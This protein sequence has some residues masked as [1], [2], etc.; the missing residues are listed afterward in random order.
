MPR[1][2]PGRKTVGFGGL[3]ESSRAIKSPI[4]APAFAPTFLGPAPENEAPE[5]GYDFGAA[6]A[7]VGA[8]EPPP[9]RARAQCLGEAQAGK[10][11]DPETFL[12]DEVYR[13]P[14]SLMCWFFLLKV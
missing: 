12:K 8:L 2:S 11:S 10:L 13:S 6:R 9:V 1:G 4:E 5:G 7:R 3:L 14:P